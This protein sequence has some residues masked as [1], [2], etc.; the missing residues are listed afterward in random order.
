MIGQNRGIIEW[1]LQRFTEYENALN[2]KSG[3]MLHRARGG[4]RAFR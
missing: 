2:G 4:K 1:Y 3:G